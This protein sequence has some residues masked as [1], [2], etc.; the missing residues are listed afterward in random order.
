MNSSRKVNLKSCI[1]Y[2]FKD[3]WNIP[4][5]LGLI[6]FIIADVL[7]FISYFSFCGKWKMELLEIS[8]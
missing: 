5:S 4:D 6:I 7:L 1:K 8:K 2:Y 3:K